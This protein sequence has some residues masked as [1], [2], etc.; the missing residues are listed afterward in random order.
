MERSNATLYVRQLRD[1]ILV[2]LHGPRLWAA[3]PAFTSADRADYNDIEPH[4][5]CKSIQVRSRR[6][7][8][9]RE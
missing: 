5:C 2:C 3:V 9:L 8:A 6:K 1:I 7:G 4:T